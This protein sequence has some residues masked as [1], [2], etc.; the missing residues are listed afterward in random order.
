M[1]VVMVDEDNDAH[2]DGADADNGVPIAACVFFIL[3]FGLDVTCQMPCGR[4][5]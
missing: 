4:Y 3:H 5:Q 1:L 2:N